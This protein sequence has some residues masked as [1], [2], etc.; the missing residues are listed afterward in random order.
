MK[1]TQLEKI[2]GY[3]NP[4]AELRRLAARVRREALVAGYEGAKL[5]RRTAG[6]LS[7]GNSANAELTTDLIR[8][9][10]RSRELIRNNHFARKAQLEWCAKTI[11]AGILPRWSKSEAAANAWA[12]WSSECSSDGLP[13]FEALQ[14]LVAG[15]WFESGEVLVRRR[16]R[17]PGDGFTVPLQLQVMESDYVDSTKNGQMEGG[18]AV[19][20]IQFDLLGRRTGYWLYSQHP[21]DAFLAGS[22]RAGMQSKLV[23]A[24]DVI[25]VYE[26]LRPSQA[27]G[28]PRL[29]A[30]MLAMR[31]IDDWE[32]AELVRK[33]TEAC[34][35]AFVTSPEGEALALTSQTTDA[36]GNTVE[37]FE[38]GMITR[39]KPGEDVK[40]NQPAAAG[41]YADYKR[42]RVRDLAAGIGMP[43]EI[44]TGDLSQVNY[45]SYRA[46]L[47][48]FKAVVEAAQWSILIP[49]L[50]DRVMR[51][52]AEAADLAGLVP[53]KEALS[54]EWSPPAFELLDREAEAKADALQLQ[55]GTMTWPQAV[56]RQGFDPEKQ[57]AEVE[58]YSERLRR[59][60]VTFTGSE[61]GGSDAKAAQ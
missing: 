53:M 5:G 40:L 47:L 36:A 19:Q 24:E 27:R 32:D 60:G 29:A 31:D 39:L 61:K 12:Q 34:L 28:V 13:H 57:L 7:S 30:V 16:G 46:G 8:L 15:A 6:W 18:Y 33:K 10:E 25:H 48:S 52:W 1:R 14:W 3:F 22:F 56:A 41:G 45:S 4:T 50:C 42:A 44:L 55:A 9:R 54:A 59:A 35:A 58:K 11:G 26:A 43:Y 37:A 2:I 21:G 51:W 17:R 20:G 49:L 23:P 38:P